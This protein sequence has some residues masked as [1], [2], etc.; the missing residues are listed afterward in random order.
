MKTHDIP[1]IVRGGG[2]LATGT[3][4][5]LRK[6]GFP[7]V[8]LETAL[9]TT[10]RRMAS[11]SQAAFDGAASVEGMTCRLIKDMG[12]FDP[13]EVNLLVD[14]GRNSISEIKPDILID[15]SMSKRN[16]EPIIGLAPLTIALGPGFTAPQ[17]AR[18]VIETQRG[19]TL[20]RVIT[21][22]SAIP[23]TGRPGNIMGYTTE[24][25]LRAPAAG[26]LV[27]DKIIG[28]TAAAG[29]VIG[30]IGGLPVTAQIAGVIRELIHPSVPCFS[31]M[32]IG[33]IDPRGIKEY[34]FTISDKS[35]SVAGGVMEAVSRFYRR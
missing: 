9:P 25:I 3:V 23:N 35:L 31:G 30:N 2:D 11:F 34:C 29:D 12:Q 14:P 8:V 26:R 20:G 22:G 1:V 16:A 7:V 10:V 18:C 28:D 4:Y 15:A 13:D 27:T 32:K 33:D 6:A 17:D 19:H 21:N 5:R 24:R